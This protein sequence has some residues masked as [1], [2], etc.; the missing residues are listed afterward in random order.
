[1]AVT[2]WAMERTSV[3]VSVDDYVGDRLPGVCCIT[4]EPTP[5]RI[6]RNTLIDRPSPAWMLLVV[7]GP[8]G[9]LGLAVVYGMGQRSYLNGVLPLSHDAYTTASRRRLQFA[10]VAVTIAVLLIAAAVTTRIGGIVAAF[11]LALVAGSWAYLTFRLL[12]R[13]SLDASRR[14]VTVR[15][16]HPALALAAEEQAALRR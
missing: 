7:L 4:G 15:N 1:M 5:D 16:V 8:I 2:W 3:T 14:W 9:W 13:V 11:G 10:G 6:T 12:P